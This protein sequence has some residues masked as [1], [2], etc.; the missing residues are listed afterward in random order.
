MNICLI[1]TIKF[2]SISFYNIR[3]SGL[4]KKAQSEGIIITKEETSEWIQ[5]FNN[6]FPSLSNNIQEICDIARNSK[7]FTT[8]VGTNVPLEEYQNQNT[9]ICNLIVQ[10][11]GFELVSFNFILNSFNVTEEYS[12]SILYQFIYF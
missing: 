1:V 3:K 11:S 4:M 7:A 5:L 2:K 8:T 12:L 10:T 6:L 9:T